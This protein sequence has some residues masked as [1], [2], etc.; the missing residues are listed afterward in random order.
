MKR[1]LDYL[2][3]PLTLA[4]IALG[5]SAIIIAW[6]VPEAQRNYWLFGG[7]VLFLF[8]PGILMT[9]WLLGGEDPRR[10]QARQDFLDT[11]ESVSDADKRVPSQAA[12]IRGTP[13]RTET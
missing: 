5:L 6:V 4:P 2:Y 13:A 1:F 7:V 11:L 3:S 8:G 12:Q 9:L 10:E